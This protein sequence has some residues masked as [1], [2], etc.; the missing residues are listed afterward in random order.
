M[1][2]YGDMMSGNCLKVR[3]VADHLGLAYDW[4]PVDIMKGESRT[5][6]YLARFPAGQVP[7]VEFPDGRCL[8]QSNAII[9]YLARGSALLPDDPWTQAKIDE[10]LFWEQYS[11]E[12]SV[13]KPLRRKP[14]FSCMVA[15]VWLADSA[16]IERMTV[17]S[18]ATPPMCG[19]RSLTHSPLSPRCRKAKS[20][21]RKRPT[22]PKKTS[23]F[24]SPPRGCPW[25][26]ASSGL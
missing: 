2:V 1:K 17:S 18:S 22:C 14:E 25:R 6:K 5:P 26:L 21:C 3:Y 9:R 15:G 20:F 7:G 4:I 16:T 19:N 23:G 8:A 10:W 13:G 24:S 12:P 11:H